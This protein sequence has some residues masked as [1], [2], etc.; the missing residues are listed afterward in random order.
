V[1]LCQSVAAKQT[2]AVLLAEHMLDPIRYGSMPGSYCN[3][4]LSRLAPTVGAWFSRPMYV[5]K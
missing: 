2:G 1:I 5:S 4:T 3:C